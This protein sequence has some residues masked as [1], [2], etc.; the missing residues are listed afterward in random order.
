VSKRKS[1]LR[2]YYQPTKYQFATNLILNLLEKEQ[3]NQ[4]YFPKLPVIN[5]HS[6]TKTEPLVFT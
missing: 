1:K 5:Q 4:R 6:V 3:R 2:G